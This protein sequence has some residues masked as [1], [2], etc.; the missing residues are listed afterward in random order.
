M[1]DVGCEGTGDEAGFSGVLK[2]DLNGWNTVV[3]GPAR[4]RRL[5]RG[6]EDMV[7]NWEEIVEGGRVE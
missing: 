1:V 2:G 3:E 4:R 6:V 5:G 7:D